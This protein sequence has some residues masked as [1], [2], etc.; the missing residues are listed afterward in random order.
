MVSVREKTEKRLRSLLRGEET[1]RFRIVTGPD[2][3]LRLVLDK[4]PGNPGTGFLIQDEAHTL[5]DEVM[6]DLRV[7]GWYLKDYPDKTANKPG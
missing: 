1:G 5:P 7:K 3:R 6:L 2:E 4:R